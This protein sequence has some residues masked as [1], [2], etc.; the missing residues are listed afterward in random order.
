MG[1]RALALVGKI[2][3]PCC[4]WAQQSR[5]CKYYPVSKQLQTA[6]NSSKGDFIWLFLL[7]IVYYSQNHAGTCYYEIQ[8]AKTHFFKILRYEYFKISK[9]TVKALWATAKMLE[10]AWKCGPSIF[11]G[12]CQL[13]RFPFFETE[14]KT[15]TK[16]Q[17]IQYFCFFWSCTASGD[18]MRVSAL[19]WVFEEIKAPCLDLLCLLWIFHKFST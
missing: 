10:N 11:S 6:P 16:T 9:P 14:K 5:F 8:R 7:F 12:K 4:F 2:L 1:A 19:K 13:L 3:R 18:V 15:V 17:K